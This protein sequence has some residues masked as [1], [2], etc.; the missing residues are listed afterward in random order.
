MIIDVFVDGSSKNNGKAN[1]LAG[2]GAYFPQMEHLNISEKIDETSE[3][4]SNNV[5]ELLAC[6]KAIE[7]V[8]EFIPD[9]RMIIIYSDSKLT[10]DSITEWCSG[11]EK[12]NWVKKD[13]KP[14]KNVELVKKLYKYYCTNNIKFIHARAHQ[15]EPL[16]KMSSEHYVWHGNKMADLL[17]KK[18]IGL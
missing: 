1:C 14:V 13:K 6:I 3:K 7:K 17:A 15:A 18:C 9:F 4:V 10:I 5:G 2:Y 11:W 8:L 16:N 12:N